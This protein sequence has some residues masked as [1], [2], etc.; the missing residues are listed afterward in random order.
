M[1][2]TS[3]AAETGSSPDDARRALLTR[4]IAAGAV[5]AA[6]VLAALLLFV[7]GDDDYVVEAEFMNG[8]QLGEGNGVRVAGATVGTVEDLGVSDDGQAIVR[9]SVD[10]EY[11]PLRRGTRAVIKQTSQSGIANR[12]IDLYLGPAGGEE[13]EDG[14]RLSVDETQTAVELDQL[15]AIFDRKTRASTQDFIEGSDEMFRGRGAQLRRAVKYLNPSLST[16][17][18]LFRELSRDEPLLERFLVD[19]AQ[20]VGALAERRD[21]LR[22]LVSNANTTLRA[23]GDQ[24]LALA[25]SVELL[26]PFMRRA[27]TTFVNLRGALDDVDPLVKVS[28]PAVRRLGPFLDAARAFAA[29]AEPT[30]RDLR[31]TIRRRGRSNDLIELVRSFPPLARAALDPRRVNGAVRRGAFPESEEALRDASE[32]ISLLRPYTPDLVGWFEDFSGTGGYDAAGGFS[33]SQLNLT[34]II[35]GPEPRMRQ[36]RRCPGAADAPA[37]DGS[38]VLPA[39]ERERLQCEESHRAV[40]GP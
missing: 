1:S 16:G 34:E 10:E 39:S 27:N 19:S 11:A 24:Q 12:F 32:T 3:G 40:A 18:R 38:N 33:R 36:F 37:S 35:Y 4:A 31:L 20:F 2:A 5:I 28:K 30:I 22:S 15:F 14:G 17:T 13:I 7:G 6:V 21:D 23:L 25:E 29:D 26:P 8:G 9:F